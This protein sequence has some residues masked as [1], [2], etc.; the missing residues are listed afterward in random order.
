M[1]IHRYVH[2][3]ENPSVNDAIL[4]QIWHCVILKLCFNNGTLMLLLYYS[5]SVQIV[6]SYGYVIKLS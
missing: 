4:S 3:V 1:S 5:N 2:A 6:F